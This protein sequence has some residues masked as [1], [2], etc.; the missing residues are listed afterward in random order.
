M[1]LDKSKKRIAKRSKMGFQ[2]YPQISLTYFGK[3]N[4]HANE[5]AVEFIL[6]ENAEAQTERFSSKIDARE[7]ET[8][9]SAIVKMIERSEAKTVIQNET[10]F[11]DV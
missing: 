11:I 8:I 7:D 9:Q 10:V 4:N 6:E 1:N 2:G 3:T 5:V